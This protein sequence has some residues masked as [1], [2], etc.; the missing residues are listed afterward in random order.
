MESR[1]FLI[2]NVETWVFLLFR[3]KGVFQRAIM[4]IKLK[5]SDISNQNEHFEEVLTDKCHHS[6]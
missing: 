4:W 1:M 6:N 3:L 5:D 2:P